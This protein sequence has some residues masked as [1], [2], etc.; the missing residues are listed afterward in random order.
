M[1]GYREFLG[2]DLNRKLKDLAAK[3]GFA[4][5]QVHAAL[6]IEEFYQNTTRPNGKRRGLAECIRD[7]ISVDSTGLSAK[8]LEKKLASILEADEGDVKCD[9]VVFQTLSIRNFGCFPKAILSFSTDEKAPLTL[10]GGRNGVG[11]T[12]ILEAIRSALYGVEYGWKRPVPALSKYPVA[13]AGYCTSSPTRSFERPNGSQ[14]K[15]PG[16]CSLALKFLVSSPIS[17]RNSIM[18]IQRDFIYYEPWNARHNRPICRSR[19][20]EN[21]QLVAEN[22]DVDAWIN[23]VIP[24]STGEYFLF[25]ADLVGQF[26][27]SANSML[28]E[29][30]PVVLRFSAA[31]RLVDDLKQV[32]QKISNEMRTVGGMKTEQNQLRVKLNDL[33]GVIEKGRAEIKIA[34]AKQL[35][36]EQDLKTKK[37]EAEKLEKRRYDLLM[38]G[39]DETRQTQ[40]TNVCVELENAESKIRDRETEISAIVKDSIVYQLLKIPLESAVHSASMKSVL[41]ADAE[42]VELVRDVKTRGERVFVRESYDKTHLDEIFEPVREIVQSSGTS[43]SLELTSDQREGLI[44][45]L[46]VSAQRSLGLVLSELQRLREEAESCRIRR[47]RL[48]PPQEEMKVLYEKLQ[49]Q[50]K[51][52][53]ADI[54]SIHEELSILKHGIT[55]NRK[56]VEK[57][58]S[59]SADVDK[60][61]DRLGDFNHERKRVD[62]FR[63]LI[64]E[65]TSLFISSRLNDL[66]NEIS[67]LYCSLSHDA[68]TETK[69]K[70]DHDT[71][72]PEVYLEGEKTQIGRL[73]QGEKQILAISM[74]GGLSKVSGRRFPVVIDTPFARLDAEHRHRLSHEYLRNLSHQVILLSLDTEVTGPWLRDLESCLGKGYHIVK[75]SE[76]LSELLDGYLK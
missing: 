46:M 16:I 67:Q 75:K 2:D 55:E 52:V 9:K 43:A 5:V 21:E 54:D 8:E 51:E 42:L 63:R 24:E 60:K 1:L 35:K 50:Q 58:K 20:L 7:I 61:V 36:L 62:S 22:E 11:K 15:G 74:I 33:T 27:T 40:Y 3:H 18:E 69:V 13:N 65:F 12:T 57:A 53:R 39:Y 17:K 23:A 70:F 28:Q 26:V 4:A 48:K 25:D 6:F 44:K 68:A 59:E 38:G 37:A 14:I 66:G 72:E 76:D 73:N 49:V 71:L 34:E 29:G 31:K 45:Q 64:E 41:T 32:D 19:L 47:D 30:L 10:V 56:K